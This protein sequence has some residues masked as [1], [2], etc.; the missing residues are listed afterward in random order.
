MSD[1]LVIGAG[2]FGLS[3]SA[4]LRHRGVE[5]TVVGRPMDTWRAHMPLGMF[6][7][8]EPYGSAISSASDGYDIATY[9][10][11]RG[12]DDYV[13]RV[14]PL[15]LERF[16]GYSAWFTEQ[17]VPGV[18]DVTVTSVTPVA[19]G[20]KVE[21]AEEPP[22]IARQV[23]IA[24]GLL[25]HMY[26]P[27]ELSGLPSDLMTH[28]SVHDRLDQFR[29]RRVAVIGGGQ[30]AL[31][32][33]ALLQEAGAEVQVIARTQEII[34]E[35]QVPEEVGLLGY[36]KSPP[37]KLCEGW[38]CVAA[39]SPDVFRLLPESVRVRKALN[40]FGPKG[41]WWLRDR[42]EGVVEV[43][44]GHPLKS[45]EPQGSGVLLRLGGA[46]Q[47]SVAVDHV[48][49]GTGFRMDM[50]RLTFLSEEIQAGVVTRANLPLVN[51]AGE[52]AVP[53]LYFAGALTT[54]SLGPGVRFIS[55]THQTAAQLARSVARRARKG[56]G[57]V[58]PAAVPVSRRPLATAGTGPHSVI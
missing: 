9:S 14:G 26:I 19:D 6:L 30:S 33:G 23:I 51:R 52:S 17:L 21:F 24:T 43:L 22:V 31:Q 53:G 8:S 16:L 32:T 28:S 4:H 57:T 39:D 1:V 54:V 20:F 40:S 27:S 35:E 25:P 41:A 13:D 37:S 47:T 29:G 48:I 55:G 36:I 49:A 46:K 56:A 18:R 10:T 42:V 58:A 11:L 15:S 7:K 44:T 2:P 3:I 34:W 38:G 45:A 50:A 5:H 12:F